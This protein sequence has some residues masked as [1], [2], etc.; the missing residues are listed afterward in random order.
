MKPYIKVATI[1]DAINL[2]K[3]LRKE[4]IEEIKAYANIKPKEA[5]I[6][7]I[8]TSKIPLGVFNQKGEIVSLCG[9]RSINSYLGQVWLLASPKIQDNFSMTFL[10]HCRAVADVL[11]KDHKILFNYVDARNELHIKW[12]KWCGFTFINK[13]EE[14]G[15]EKRPFY[16]FV[17]I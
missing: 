4:D 2:S 7:G 14:F 16:E 12:L 13:H 3:D 6:L 1:Q 10:R 9:V 8:R 11:T 5:L 15:F 17:R